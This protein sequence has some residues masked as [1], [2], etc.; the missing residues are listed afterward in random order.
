MKN[1]K[2]KTNQKQRLLSLGFDEFGTRSYSRGSIIIK[3]DHTA[4]N[5]AKHRWRYF[6]DYQNNKYKTFY[7]FDKLEEYI[8]SQELQGKGD[9]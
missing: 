8:V 7:S 2:T 1:Q 6:T 4:D 3:N 5:P 9:I